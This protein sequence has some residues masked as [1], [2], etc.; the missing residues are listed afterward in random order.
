MYLNFK[1]ELMSSNFITELYCY[2]TNTI[3]AYE[4]SYNNL[5]LT[6][7]VP[8]FVKTKIVAIQ[9]T[10]IMNYVGSTLF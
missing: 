10:A 7:I 3:S 9:H 1:S 2:H 8:V 6:I 5:Y 4:M